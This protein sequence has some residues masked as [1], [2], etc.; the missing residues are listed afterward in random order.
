MCSVCKQRYRQ[1]YGNFKRDQTSNGQ[2]NN[3]TGTLPQEIPLEGV[4]GVY[5]DID[6]SNMIDNVET[7]RNMNLS[8]SDTNTN[9]SYVM[10]NTN[11]YLTPYQPTDEDENIN[12]L[13]DFKSESS[14]SF[15]ENQIS[16]GHESTSSSSYIIGEKSGYLNPYQ[17]IIYSADIHDYS[18][19]HKINDS[20]SSG[21]DTQTLESGYLN[22][23]QPVVPDR[24][25]HEYKSV[26]KCSDKSD[27]TVSNT[28]TNETE[29]ALPPYNQGLKSQT[30]T[31]EYKSINSKATDTVSNILDTITDDS[32]EKFQIE[33][34]ES[35][36]YVQMK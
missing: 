15:G 3:I 11:D 35:S 5:E 24:Y 2:R 6:E 29:V 21:S 9:C 19:T 13:S 12:Q 30:D 18:F 1:I 23:Y 28:C 31:Y 4:E 22:P 32:V 8:D 25:L 7:L 33:N 17:P 14:S 20:G 16:S 34:D 10:P 36:S 27:S 26:L